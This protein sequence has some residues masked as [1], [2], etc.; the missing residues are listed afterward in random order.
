MELTQ[1]KLH[2]SGKIEESINLLTETLMREM[3]RF[4]AYD[5]ASEEIRERT[6]SYFQEL[7]RMVLEGLKEEDVKEHAFKWGEKIGHYSV[8]NNGDLGNTIRGVTVYKNVIWSF[9]FEEGKKIN[10]QADDI[11][12]VINEIDHI[13]NMMVHGFSTAF[14]KNAEQLLKESRELYLKISVPIVPI[15]SKL[16][17]LPL[18]GDINEMRSETLIADTLYT[19]VRKRIETLVIDLSGVVEVDLIGIEVLFKLLKSLNLLGVKPVITGM[20]GEISKTFVNLGIMLEDI[21][22][23]SNL[24]QALK[25][26]KFF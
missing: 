11:L 15:S 25:E 10:A 19:C 9:I 6:N 14:T 24:E 2:L 4:Y 13:F 21:A 1:L 3:S 8:E 16:A 20:S 18:I 12:H 26:L 22:I 7:V 17:V 23:Y 5:F